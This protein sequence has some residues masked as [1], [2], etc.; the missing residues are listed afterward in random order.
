M[1]VGRRVFGW[2][3]VVLLLGCLACGD[4]TDA[5]DPLVADPAVAPYVGDWEAQALTLTNTA[6]PEIVAHL[7]ALGATFTLN[8]QP[9]GR[10]TA[11]LVYWGQAST[12]IGNLSVS[13]S[14]LTLHRDFP[15][16]KVTPGTFEFFGPDRFTLDG[17]SEFD[18][19]DDDTDEAALAHFDLVRR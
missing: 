6:N 12:E 8:V 17:D 1:N 9:S 15:T 14:T 2:T 3:G 19:N 5:G 7:V 11:I 10:Y 4:G 13:G 18:F 16:T